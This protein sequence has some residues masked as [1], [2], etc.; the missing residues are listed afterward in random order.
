MHAVG[1]GHA[2]VATLLLGRGAD[3]DVRTPTSGATALG[4]A[5]TRGDTGIVKLLLAKGADTEA[6]ESSF[7]MTPLA[8]AAFKG[9]LETVRALLAAGANPSATDRD[10]LTPLAIATAADNA[11]VAELLADAQPRHPHSGAGLFLRTAAF[12]P[13]AGWALADPFTDQT[14]FFSGSSLLRAIGGPEGTRRALLRAPNEIGAQAFIIRG[15]RAGWLP[16]LRAELG[17]LGTHPL[18]TQR[19]IETVQTADGLGVVVSTS[20][21]RPGLIAGADTTWVLAALTFGDEI[22]IIDAGGPSETFRPETILDA[23]AALDLRRDL[24]IEAG[25][26]VVASGPAL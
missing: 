17:E 25:P 7:G 14:P 20:R 1:A 16:L 15:P 9:H 24:G 22:L 26:P 23:I 2:R 19:P 4:L 11:G 5:A 10:G 3:P 8:V 13:P 12:A 21:M 6:R 18:V